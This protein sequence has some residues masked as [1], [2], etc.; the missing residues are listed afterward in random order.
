M[1]I[2]KLQKD[3]VAA[4]HR[5]APIQAEVAE[6]E[7]AHLKLSRLTEYIV[8]TPSLKA[9]LDGL[10][11]SLGK[12][13]AKLKNAQD[14]ARQLR[15]RIEAET[16]KT[17]DTVAAAL[18]EQKAKLVVEAK[19]VLAIFIADQ[20]LDDVLGTQRDEASR[21]LYT[22]GKPLYIEYLA[23]LDILDQIAEIDDDPLQGYRII[24]QPRWQMAI[25]E[26][27]GRDLDV[28]ARRH[29]SLR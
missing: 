27:N 23:L 4:Q 12:R 24:F 2:E 5:I 7:V 14:R 1:S 11:R 3:M 6:A 28:E 20:S 25:A 13:Q 8:P 17:A 22:L 10:S 18:A 21:L 26:Q 29:G 16:A 9:D 19:K 15:N